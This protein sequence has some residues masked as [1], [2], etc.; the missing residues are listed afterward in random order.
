MHIS[1]ILYTYMYKY[2]ISVLGSF[3]VSRVQTTAAKAT[4]IAIFLL[5]H[6]RILQCSWEVHF[7]ESII[8]LSF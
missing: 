8:E 6:I 7:A 5:Y 1:L 3:E 2:H 4:V